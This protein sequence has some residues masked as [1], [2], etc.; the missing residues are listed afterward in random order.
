MN[1]TK[2]GDSEPSIL[3]VVIEQEDGNRWAVGISSDSEIE[4]IKDRSVRVFGM[5]QGFSD[6]MNLPSVVVA[7][8]DESK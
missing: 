7:S 5:Y 3:S 4:N 6:V 8:T 1:Q 2:I